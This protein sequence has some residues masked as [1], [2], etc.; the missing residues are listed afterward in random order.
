MNFRL[1][2]KRKELHC[3]YSFKR[4]VNEKSTWLGCVYIFTIFATST[5]D[6][7]LEETFSVKTYKLY[8]TDSGYPVPIKWR[9]K[10]YH[11]LVT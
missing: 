6:L 5:F 10:I 7:E 9:L 11:I 8:W 2:R 4:S 1:L 3:K